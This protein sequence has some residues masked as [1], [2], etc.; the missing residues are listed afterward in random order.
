MNVLKFALIACSMSA[1]A[2]HAQTSPASQQQSQQP[3]QQVAQANTPGAGSAAERRV[4]VP[5]AKV[6]ECVGP[7]SFCTVYFGS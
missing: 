3:S 5:K 2:A 6:D 4:V 1:A 7:V